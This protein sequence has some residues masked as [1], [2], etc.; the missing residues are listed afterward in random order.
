VVSPQTVSCFCRR[1]PPCSQVMVIC[2]MT[3]Q[4]VGHDAC[5]FNQD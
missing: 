1:V 4:E 2:P 3:S 5:M